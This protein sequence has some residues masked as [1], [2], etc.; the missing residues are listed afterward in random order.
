MPKKEKNAAAIEDAAT[1]EELIKEANKN[2]KE[3]LITEEELAK[4]MIEHGI[5]TMDEIASKLEELSEMKRTPEE[6]AQ[7]EKY[8]EEIKRLEVRNA[9]IA[10]QRSALRSKVSYYGF[11]KSE[12]AELQ[13][14]RFEKESN[15]L[16]IKQ[17]IQEI[18]MISK[19]RMINQEAAFKH[20]KSIEECRNHIT[21][22]QKRMNQYFEDGEKEKYEK[23]DSEYFAEKRKLKELTANVP[24]VLDERTDIELE[25]ADLRELI[26]KAYLYRLN[27]YLQRI[28]EETSIFESYEEKTVMIEKEG[29]WK[30]PIGNENR[31]LFDT[32]YFVN[33]FYSG[34][35]RS[36]YGLED[37]SDQLSLY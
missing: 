14:L 22:I 35:R 21:E 33:A 31:Y 27:Y 7:R 16:K 36:L 1:V 18:G 24:V 11:S 29:S 34:V 23:A 9:E 5:P 2:G 17:R 26:R 6:I 8:E 12:E 4:R 32:S 30:K 10:K 37:I 19:N 13:N 15:D 25:G 3:V 28:A 20:R